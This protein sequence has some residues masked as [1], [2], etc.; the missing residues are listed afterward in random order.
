MITILNYEECF[1]FSHRLLCGLC[2][3]CRFPLN[4]ASF[5][6]I[7]SWSIEISAT[8]FIATNFHLKFDVSRHPKLLDKSKLSSI[9]TL[10]L[11]PAMILQIQGLLH[12]TRQVSCKH[13]S[14]FFKCRKIWRSWRSNLPWIH[15]LV[16]TNKSSEID[17]NRFN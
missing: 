8:R 13:F 10:Y 6:I 3:Q 11:S 9:R 7:C 16:E 15:F 12:C 4:A 5:L 14:D 2:L 1:F 17:V